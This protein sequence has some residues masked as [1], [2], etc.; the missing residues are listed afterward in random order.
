MYR[1]LEREHSDWQPQSRAIIDRVRAGA[2]AQLPVDL[3]S[4]LE[5]LSRTH[6]LDLAARGVIKPHIDSV[7]VL[8]PSHA[9]LSSFFF[10]QFAY[11]A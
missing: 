6:V 1:E 3:A 7:K 2:V 10:L 5:W 9:A 8:P 4:T 11:Y